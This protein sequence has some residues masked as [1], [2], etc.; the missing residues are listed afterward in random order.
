[1]D[2][3]VET[4][5]TETASVVISLDFELRW[6]VLDKLQ[7]DFRAYRAN[8]EGVHDVVPMTLDV[9]DQHGATVT[10]AVVGSMLCDGW[11]EWTDRC[12]PWPR[13]ER[14]SLCWRDE[15]KGSTQ[16]RALYFAP[17]LVDQV[18]ARGHEIASHSFTH[19]YMNEPGVTPEDVTQDAEAMNRLFAD[20]WAAR[21]SS[22]V[23]PRNQEGRLRE[24]QDAGIK[25]WRANP[26]LWF[27]DPEKPGGR[28]RRAL[29]VAD[30]FLPR[31]RRRHSSADHVRQRASHLVR[32]Q[33]PDQAWHLHARRIV[34]DSSRLRGGEVLHLWW[35]PHNMGADPRRSVERLDELL[36]SIS[37]ETKPS[38]AFR[39]MR[40]L[41]SVA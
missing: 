18:R 39:A 14:R 23:F 28:G 25:S 16:D 41:T 8:L 22:F 26:D 1:M 10:W 12:P 24:L 5:A 30:S 27:W 31:P 7:D 21:P 6:G 33:L 37:S 32:F 4:S 20:R 9:F 13:Y 29:R 11:D 15:L 34:R 36:G 40:D 2:D 3:H 19:L 35:H 17:E 38:V